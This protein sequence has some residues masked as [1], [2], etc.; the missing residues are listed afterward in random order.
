MNWPMEEIWRKGLGMT[1]DFTSGSH[2]V[3]GD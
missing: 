1:A 3:V 2:V